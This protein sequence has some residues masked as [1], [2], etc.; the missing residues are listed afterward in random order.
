MS[1][2]VL[3]NDFSFFPIKVDT[4]DGDNEIVVKTKLYILL[5]IGR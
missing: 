4:L 1:L 2:L 5:V 3:V